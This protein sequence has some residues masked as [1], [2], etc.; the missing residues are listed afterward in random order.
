MVQ[1]RFI[2]ILAVLAA[3]FSSTAISCGGK[4]SPGTAS[5]PGAVSPADKDPFGKYPEPVTFTTGLEVSPNEEWPPGDS[6]LN[7]QYIRHIEEQLNIKVDV[8]WTASSADYRQKVNLAI[9]SNS[10]P[11]GLVANDSQLNQMVKSGQLADLSQAYNDFA[12]DTMRR[13]IDSSGGKALENGSF[14]GELYGLTSTSDG[15]FE[16]LWI[17]KDWMDKLGLAAPKSMAD[18]KAIAKAFVEK[19]PGGNG[20]GRTIGISGPQNGGYLYSTFLTSGTNVYGFEPLFE[21]F[22][23]Y[24]GWWLRDASGNPVYGSITGE[25]RA[26]L[27][28]LAAWYR[29]GLID[30]EMGIRQDSTEAVISGR[31]GMFSGGWWMGYYMLPDVIK[32]NPQANFQC[33]AVPVDS[34][35][36]YR[37]RASSASYMYAVVNKN[38]AHPEAV[39][40]LN[41]L[42]IR[43]ESQF[44]QRNGSIGNFPMRIAFGML[45]EGTRTLNAMRDVLSGA[46]AINDYTE[47]DFRIYKLLRKDLEKIRLVKKEPF[48][49]MDIAYWDPAADMTAWQRSYSIM[50]GW[51]ALADSKIEKVFSLTHSMTPVME[52]R[53]SN[54]KALEDETFMRIIM[55]QAPIESFDQFVKD[56]KAQGGERITGEVKEL[57]ASK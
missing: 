29:E 16:F 32:N 40:K 22:N 31:S 23:A 25:T 51:A 53:W 44:D 9:S 27:Q 18:L 11:D 49:N 20:P 47:E 38:Y 17:R 2:P 55:G 8:V 7:N 15:D 3:V 4:T 30:P 5:A 50:V 21:A 33:Y 42:L 1:N 13:L 28:E 37:P 34:R 56:W 48:D 35:G 6:P 12:S 24:P 26:A 14:H 54:L 43:D 45:D 19:D 46:A 41:N 57:T 36:V 39:I 10:L 52:S